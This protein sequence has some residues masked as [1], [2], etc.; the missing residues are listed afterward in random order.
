MTK[1]LAPAALYGL[2]GFLL[3]GFLRSDLGLTAASVVA[4][5]IGVVVPAAIATR[6]LLRPGREE[7]RRLKQSDLRQRTIEAEILRIAGHHGGKVTLV[8]IVRE[9][10]VT[11][12]EAKTAADSL[13]HQQIGDLEITESGVIVYV[14]HDIRHLGEKESARGVLE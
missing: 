5:G 2:A 8:E 3:L 6:L 4:L 13:V 12:E 9:L 14:F 7:Q 11:P 1:Y 10:A